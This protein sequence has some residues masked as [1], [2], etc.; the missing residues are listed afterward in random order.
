MESIKNE[1]ATAAWYFGFGA[2]M[3]ASVFIERRKIRPLR[4]EAA[5]IPTHALCFNVLGIPYMDP[6]NG[7]IRPLNP[8]DTD[9]TACVHGVAYLL[10]SDDL[11]RVILSEGGG[12]AY[13]VARLNAKLLLDDSPIVVDTLIGRHNVDASNERLPSARYI[14]VLT[15]GANELNLPLSYQRRLAEQPIY[16]PKSGWWFQLGVALFLW[17]WTRAAIITERLVYKHQGPDGHVPAW[18]LFI[19][20]CLL[21]LMWAQ[22]D[23]IHGPIFGRGDG[24]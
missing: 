21:W 24:R 15:R 10:T 12:I 23:Y 16:Q 7:G 1:P 18:F 11:K 9:A 3:S 13:Q 19:F 20:D 17:P 5:C 8:D 6:G 2:N 22:H 14:G 4:T